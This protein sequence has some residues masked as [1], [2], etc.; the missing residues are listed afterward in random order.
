MV[1]GLSGSGHVCAPLLPGL[2]SCDS[3]GCGDPPSA[4]K[5]P[6]SSPSAPRD[7]ADPEG[8]ARNEPLGA[9]WLRGEPGE[10]WEKGCVCLGEHPSGG[11][12][13]GGGE[14]L[15]C[16]FFIALIS[17]TWA[18]NFISNLLGA[19]RAGDAGGSSPKARARPEELEGTPGQRLGT[20]G[21]LSMGCPIPQ[22]S[23]V[24][25]GSDPPVLPPALQARA[26]WKSPRSPL[27]LL[28]LI[29]VY[30]IAIISPILFII[31]I[32]A[33]SSGE[34]AAAAIL[35]PPLLL[36]TRTP[37]GLSPQP[38]ASPGQ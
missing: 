25:E 9:A 30:I 21:G 4:P 17:R 23:G 34:T 13:C 14:C 32:A 7:A 28:A 5:G 12:G 19:R 24:R 26:R 33:F 29:I 27:S 11:G 3:G 31:I 16:I 36:V 20:R 18:T 15:F 38:P 22:P 37:P 35:P 1:R 8:L 10:S 6:P 2:L